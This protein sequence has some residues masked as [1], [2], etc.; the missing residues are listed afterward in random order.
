MGVSSNLAVFRPSPNQAF[1]PASLFGLAAG[2]VIS[3]NIYVLKGLAC[4]FYY[5][6]A[7]HQAPPM[8]GDACAAPQVEEVLGILTLVHAVLAALLG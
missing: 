4:D 7:H 6:I 1:L 5:L 2:T 8:E 3:N